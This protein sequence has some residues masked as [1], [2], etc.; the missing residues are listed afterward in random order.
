MLVSQ[1]EPVL[2]R[3]LGKP[4][5]RPESFG[6][7]VLA[8]AGKHLIGF[9]RK[10][11]P[12]LIASLHDGR[13]GVERSQWKRLQALGGTVILIIEGRMAWTVDGILAEIHGRPFT[14]RQFRRF[15]YSV[16]RRGV[17]V[18]HTVDIKDTASL[19]EDLIGYH[20]EKRTGSSLPSRPGP[21]GQWGKPSSREWAAH[22]LQ[23]FPDVG[24]TV[25]EA[26]LDHFG[27][28]PMQWTCTRDELLAVPGVG[29]KRADALWKGLQPILRVVEEEQEA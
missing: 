3:C 6:C 20:T 27:S 21:I 17:A 10:T 4:S 13:M 16:S 15:V 22:L 23:S 24:P 29:P 11:V 2:L 25:A 7:D 1:T 26:I 12:D 8:Q 18:E 19:I 5:K 28:V 14:R 9:Q